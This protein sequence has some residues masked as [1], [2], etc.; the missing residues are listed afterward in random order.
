VRQLANFIPLTHV[1][2]LMRGVW[3][4]DALGAHGQELIV[5]GH[6]L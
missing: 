5:L 3:A 6:C 1:V 4:G 2:T